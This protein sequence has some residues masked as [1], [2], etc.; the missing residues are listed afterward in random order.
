LK[1]DL[2]SRVGSR[3]VGYLESRTELFFQTQ[4]MCLPSTIRGEGRRSGMDRQKRE[5]DLEK[6]KDMVL[7]LLSLSPASH[8][9]ILISDW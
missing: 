9:G 1:E 7:L 2:E 3:V 8:S 5:T 4:S 6:E